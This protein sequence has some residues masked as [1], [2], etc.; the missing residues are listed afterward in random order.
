MSYGEGEQVLWQ[1]VCRCLHGPP[2]SSIS[3][4]GAWLEEHARD[5]NSW[6]SYGE[7]EQFLWQGRSI[8]TWGE[9]L[10]RM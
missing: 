4:A 2:Q 1:G 3:A 7:E 6:V 8:G 10:G 9:W 5:L